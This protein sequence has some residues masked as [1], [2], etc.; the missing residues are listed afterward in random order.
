MLR[1][2]TDGI[3]DTLT[4]NNKTRQRKESMYLGKKKTGNTEHNKGNKTVPGKVTITR[5][6]DGRKQNNKTNCTI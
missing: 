3:F 4:W 5:T 2:S 1:S 6:E